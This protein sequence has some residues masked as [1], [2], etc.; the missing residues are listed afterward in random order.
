[1]SASIKKSK[2]PVHSFSTNFFGV[3]GYI[4]STLVWLLVIVCTLLYVQ[5]GPDSSAFSAIDTAITKQPES[6]PAAV[7]NSPV[8]KVM[9]SALLVI[10]FWAF[11]YVASRIL[12][13]VVRR[14]AGIFSKPVTAPG[15]FK[16]KFFIHAIGLVLL[17]VL[18]IN[19]PAYMWLSSA[20]SLLGLISGSIGIAALWLQRLL[21]AWHRVPFAQIL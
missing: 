14:V 9:L 17:V 19:V 3:I 20:I 11:S 8:F 6:S 4:S 16:T 21:A 10:A 15:L 12:S 1:M 13:R 18:L 7:Y 5:I 2:K